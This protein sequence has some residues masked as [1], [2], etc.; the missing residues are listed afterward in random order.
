MMVRPNTIDS[1]WATGV[2]LEAVLHCHASSPL[3]H[4]LNLGFDMEK[5]DAAVIKAKKVLAGVH[6][7][8]AVQG[9]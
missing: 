4:T 3:V 8:F 6:R 9:N 2:R 1:I 7:H 5:W